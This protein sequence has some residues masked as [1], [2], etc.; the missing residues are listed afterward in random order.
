MKERRRLSKNIRSVF[1]NLS[2]RQVLSRIQMLSEENRVTFRSVLPFNTSLECSHCGHIEKGN[3]LSQ[4][5]FVCQK[6]GYT[7][8]A[9]NN[10]SKVILKRFTTGTY[11]SCYK[12][13]YLEKY[14]VS[15]V[16][17]SI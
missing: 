5:L 3:R 13:E 11:G 6:C 1:Y 2:Y 17:T 8:N 14:D 16:S 7:D 15:Q 12:Q 9:D 4:E 10:A